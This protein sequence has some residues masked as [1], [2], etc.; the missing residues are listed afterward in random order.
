MGNCNGCSCSDR[1]EALDKQ[2]DF[3]V[4]AT[5]IDNYTIG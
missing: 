3:V 1:E 4:S 2:L 5:F